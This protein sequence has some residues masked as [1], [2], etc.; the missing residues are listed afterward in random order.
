MNAQQANTY[1]D[2]SGIPSR[3]DGL[4][5]DNPTVS[6]IIPVHNGADLLDI[7]IT[8]ALAQSH[9]LLEIIVV[10]DGSTDRTSEVASQYP[11]TL[12][13]QNNGGPSSARNAGAVRA[14]GE[15]LAFL[16]HDD[17]WRPNKTEMQLRFAKRTTGVV[18]CST[19]EQ[20]P[21]ISNLRPASAGERVTFDQLWSYNV[22]GSPSGALVRRSAFEAVNGFDLSP[23]LICAEDY[24]FWLR[25]ALANWDLVSGP[26][27]LYHYTP[28]AN[29]L[30]GQTSR[31][32]RAEHVNIE[33]IGLVASLPK[34]DI[35][36]R[37]LFSSVDYATHLIDRG[38]PSAARKY[39]RGLPLDS[40]TLKLWCRAVLPHR[41][42]SWLRRTRAQARAANNAK[43]IHSAVS[44]SR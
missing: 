29:H 11:V 35:E 2:Y 16:D 7:A 23:E 31:M 9:H 20:H 13:R 24:N 36:K 10:D 34:P 3:I 19:F 17:R 22:V 4:P 12:V 41:V 42:D 1:R 6:A 15:W 44:D 27:N 21:F 28:A 30:S 38:D 32:A 39:L 25:I 18:F 33:R 8:S 40:H 37:K 5:A 26:R 43:N 14:S